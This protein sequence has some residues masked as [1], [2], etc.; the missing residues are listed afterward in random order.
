MK[1][2]FSILTCYIILIS[3]VFSQDSVGVFSVKSFMQMVLNNHPIAKQNK[4]LTET[5]KEEVRLA[6][7]T[8]DPKLEAELFQKVFKGKTYYGYIDNGLKVPLWFGTDL[9]FGYENNTGLNVNPTDYTPPGGLMYAGVHIPIGQGMIIDERRAAI[10]Q[11]QAMQG[12]LEAEKVKMINKLLLTAAKNYWEWYFTYHKFLNVKKSFILAQDRQKAISERSK[13]GDLA[14]IDSV[15][16]LITLQ[17]REIL[18]KDVSTDLQNAR[19][20]L[21]NFLWTEDLK[22]LEIDTILVPEKNMLA[23]IIDPSIISKLIENAPQTNP[24]I[25]KLDFKIKQLS[26]DQKL[27]KDKLKPNLDFTYK[28]LTSPKN[29]I[30]ND[31]NTDYIQDNYKVMLSLSQPLFLR[32]ERAKYQ[33]SKIK[34]AQTKM[35]LLN[36]NREVANAISNTFNE[37]KFLESA[38]SLQKRMIENYKKLLEG[39]HSKFDNGES[40][41]F[42]LNSRESKLIDGEIK[43]AE[44]KSKLEK[45]KTELYYNAGSLMQDL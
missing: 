33:L 14:P 43:L 44:L 41:I 26:I 25:L 2:I 8:L 10:S 13:Q 40:S 4:M 31:L 9:K 28:Y 6:R 1:I 21:S 19:L 36:T 22:P 24:D 45:M 18:M 27:Y 32:K 35:E 16:T 29:N 42:M 3:N 20:L 5:A 38:L 17:E 30:L 23:T 12:L 7:G 37:I 15:E 11:A 34:V 39:E